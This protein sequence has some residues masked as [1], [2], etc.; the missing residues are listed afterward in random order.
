VYR[1]YGPKGVK[2]Y[3]IY[4]SL[5]HPEL[6]S[7]YVQ[8]FTI[9]ERLAHARQAEKELGATI[10]WLVDAMDNR[11]KHALGDR[12]NSEFVIDPK[13]KI[14][15]K[16]AW[17]HPAQVRKDLEE[18]VGKAKTTTKEEDIKLN[19]QPPLKAPAERGV[20]A[21]IKRPRMQPIVMEPVIKPNEPPFYAKL[22]V[23]A[24]QDLVNDGTGKLYLG[25]HL[26]PFHHAH[27]NNLTPP[28][29][30]KFELPDGVTIE[31]SSGQAAKV[32]ALSDTDP[33]EFMLDV[34]DW[35]S[36]KP[37]RLAVSYSACVEQACHVVRQE[38]LLHLRRDKDGG[39]ARGAGA[40]FW[41]DEFVKQQ[42]ARDKDGNGKLD[43]KE[44]M[45]LILPHF[46]HFD[47]DNDG[48]LDG[49][50]LKAV[51][52]WLN[53]HHA[54]GAPEKALPDTPKR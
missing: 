23:E 1:D 41:G 28:L 2:F 26:D 40:G 27:W 15:R 32:K 20:V 14:V 51:S 36:D 22:R 33:R 42:L 37:I 3:F 31:K 50:E 45:G 24:D 39:G 34:Q 7:D 9:D 6:V 13:G 44:V 11:L 38:Y 8:P 53:T 43:R 18:L 35:P 19:L 48:L 16:R 46:K 47:V 29:S 54:P 12:P 4:K 49:E 21:R 17:S 25:F 5:A 10:P 52:K 30:Y